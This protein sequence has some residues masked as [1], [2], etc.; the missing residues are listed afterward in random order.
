M[1]TPRTTIFDK[2]KN[3]PEYQAYYREASAQ[4]D[5]TIRIAELRRAQRLSQAQLA[6]KARMPQS[7][8]A[9]LESGKH[10]MTVETLIRVAAALKTRLVMQ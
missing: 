8:I 3:D 10:N 7:V 5:L 6:K 9:R 4:I 2:Y 1:K